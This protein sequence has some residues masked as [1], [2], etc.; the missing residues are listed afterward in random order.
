MKFLIATLLL[1]SSPALA[2]GYTCLSVDGDTQSIVYFAEPATD[3]GALAAPEAKQIVFIDPTLSKKSQVLAVFDSEVSTHPMG[4]GVVYVSNVDENV[5]NPGKHLGGTRVGL[6][7]QVSMKVQ[8][9]V[10][11]ARMRTLTDGAVYAA[12]VSYTKKNGKTLTQE[13]DC[14]LFLGDEVPQI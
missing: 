7:A 2:A 13:F 6:L 9:V 1:S 8:T 10:E 14:A 4:E 3:I 12:E 11:N 5:K